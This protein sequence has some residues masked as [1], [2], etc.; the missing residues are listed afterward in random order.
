M[1]GGL[2]GCVSE[3]PRRV[4]EGVLVGIGG[5]SDEQIKPNP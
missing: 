3:S 4:C 2:K 1:K 5:R